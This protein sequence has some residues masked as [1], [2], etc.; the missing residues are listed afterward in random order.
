M[1]KCV[2]ATARTTLWIYYFQLCQFDYYRYNPEIV[3]CWM[4]EIR[5]MIFITS[6]CNLVWKWG[7]S[8]WYGEVREILYETTETDFLVFFFFF[9]EKKGQTSVVFI[10]KKI[11]WSFRKFLMI[12]YSV[13][14]P[15]YVSH[16][17]IWKS[18]A[19]WIV[20]TSLCT[21]INCCIIFYIIIISSRTIPIFN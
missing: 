21:K 13:F 6:W 4:K 17:I 16:K 2:S 1:C 7:K 8:W 15:T 20:S 11:I 18:F 5:F 14:Q 3:F 12:S 10:V 19:I 9:L